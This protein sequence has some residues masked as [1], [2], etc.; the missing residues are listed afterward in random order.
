[1]VAMF[2]LLI[3]IG[4]PETRIAYEFFG[5]AKSLPVLA[6]QEAALDLQM[7]SADRMDPSAVGSR[8]LAKAPA[9]L[10]ILAYLI[11]PD[12]RATSEDCVAPTDLNARPAPA[13]E[14]VAVRSD[15][16]LEIGKRGRFCTIGC[17]GKVARDGCITPGVGRKR[18]TVPELQLPIGHLQHLC[19]S[20][21]RR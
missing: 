20:C 14:S 17:F 15:T 5:K 10:A 6:D 7:A 19:L 16:K 3:S 12:A 11:D 2:R 8:V 18:R 13:H 21:P 1:M 9:A 4:V